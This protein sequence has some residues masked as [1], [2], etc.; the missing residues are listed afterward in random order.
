MF[1]GSAKA[2]ISSP[3]WYSL[4]SHFNAFG[5]CLSFR[6]VFIGV[7]RTVSIHFVFLDGCQ[8]ADSLHI[9]T[10]RALRGDLTEQSEQKAN[11][12]AYNILFTCLD[13]FFDGLSIS[14]LGPSP[15]SP[16]VGFIR[17]ELPR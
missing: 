9:C 13:V 17:G 11:K 12:Y 1:R 6:L 4:E 10:L 5:W 14:K 15:P 2:S 7:S 3:K 16:Q 8:G